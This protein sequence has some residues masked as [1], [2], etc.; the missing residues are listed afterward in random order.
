M[1]V[2]IYTSLFKYGKVDKNEAMPEPWRTGP[3]LASDHPAGF[4]VT[5]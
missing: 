5:P 3:K 2:I 1:N 4:V